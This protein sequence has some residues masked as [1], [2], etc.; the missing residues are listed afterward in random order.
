MLSMTGLVTA[1]TSEGTAGSTAIVPNNGTEL[2]T[3]GKPTATKRPTSSGGV[4]TSSTSAGAA[5]TLV[6]GI[7]GA[8]AI[9]GGIMAAL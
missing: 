1:A 8:M 7:G 3:S 5:Q 9:V 4:A 6:A 2:S